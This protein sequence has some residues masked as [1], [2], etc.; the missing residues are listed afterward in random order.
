M[1]NISFN[2]GSWATTNKLGEVSS[3]CLLLNILVTG[4]T[5]FVGRHLCTALVSE[6]H[7]VRGTTRSA[8]SIPELLANVVDWVGL[9]DLDQP[10]SLSLAC[11]NIDVVIHLA[12]FV[13]QM[14]G[15]NESEEYDR[16]NHLGTL[17]LA[18]AAVSSGVQRFIFLSSIKVNGEGRGTPYGV[19]DIASP[20]GAYAKSKYAAERGL[21]EV[22][23]SEELE[24]VII[25]TPLIY[26]P[27]VKANFL[28]LISW[29][30]RGVPIPLAALNNQRSF[31][32][33]FNLVSLISHCL[34]H[35]K[36]C[37][38]VLFVC[39]GEAISTPRLI[40]HISTAYGVHCRLVFCPVVLLRLLGNLIGRSDSV[41]R[42]LG[43]LSIDMSDTCQRLGWK[44]PVTMQYTLKKMSV[45]GAE[46]T[47]QGYRAQ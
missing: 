19:K 26:G 16:V 36:A 22:E 31:V 21:R 18:H 12:A 38:D 11:K 34:S 35:S 43:S 6:G 27:G 41:S 29:V 15:D 33:V 28:A 13:H 44:P 3:G 7:Y 9:T 24:V 10:E 32:S 1:W 25:R 37:Q 23:Q 2:G 8:A 46:L 47:A 14:R 40:Q 4:A 39:D 30:K 20:V 5:G 42:L 45:E 17:N